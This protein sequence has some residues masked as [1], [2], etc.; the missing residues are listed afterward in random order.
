MKL[1]HTLSWQRKVAMKTKAGIQWSVSKKNLNSKWLDSNVRSVP[2]LSLLL[3]ILIYDG[4]T[5]SDASDELVSGSFMYVQRLV[6]QE[7]GADVYWYSSLRVLRTQD[8][9]LQHFHIAVGSG[10]PM[11]YKMLVTIPRHKPCKC[12]VV[13]QCCSL[14]H[15]V[16]VVII[17]TYQRL[18]LVHNFFF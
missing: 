7:Q 11:I 5:T 3:F 17:I 4:N 18:L 1:T 13:S 2:V 6:C 10:T 12:T 8:L 14:I 15:S 16:K 9:S